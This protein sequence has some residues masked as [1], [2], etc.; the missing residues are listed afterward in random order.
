[1]DNETT[2]SCRFESKHQASQNTPEL[3]NGCGK[4]WYFMKFQG[5]DNGFLY[6]FFLNHPM[7]TQVMNET[8]TSA[9]YW[10]VGK[11][12]CRERAWF[13]CGNA[14]QPGSGGRRSAFLV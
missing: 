5:K 2:V 9:A 3:G 8:V 7:E 11:D 12:C 13:N 14:M 6:M 1:L 10:A 4:L